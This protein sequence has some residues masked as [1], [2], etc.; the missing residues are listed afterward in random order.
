MTTRSPIVVLGGPA[1]DQ[2]ARV[3]YFPTVDGNVVAPEMSRRPGGVGANVAVGLAHLGNAVAI[4]GATGDDEAG[5]FLRAA[6]QS[7][8]V[9]T[10][11]LITRDDVATHSCFIAVNPRG[12]RVIYGLPG[13]VTLE[14]PEELDLAV[15][16]SARALHIAP[17]YRD[18]AMMAITVAR[19]QGLFVSY[20]PGDVRWPEGEM[21]VREIARNVDM[22]ILNQVE[23]SMLTGLAEPEQAMDRLLNWGYGPVLLTLGS[24]GVLVGDEDRVIQ[25]PAYPVKTVCD[26][27][28]AGDAFTAGAITGRLMG[29][30]LTRA[31]RLGTAVAALKI[32]RT[33]A[34]SGLPTLDEAMALAL[35][36]AELLTSTSSGG[37]DELITNHSG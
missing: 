2:I 11:H 3:P 16:R 35:H 31:A 1:L 13:T 28:G 37:I 15:V 25:L 8:G 36:P 12:E 18:V 6:L 29:L 4:L 22:L 9:D 30:S 5:K 23:A 7:A 33:G 10:S 24:L 19:A 21:A 26:T 34:Q 20:A 14:S 27:T 32:R 17:A